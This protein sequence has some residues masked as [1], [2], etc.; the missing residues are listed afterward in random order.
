[1]HS[2]DKNGACS[3]NSKNLKLNFIDF[4]SAYQKYTISTNALSNRTENQMICPNK[5]NFVNL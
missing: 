5:K 4:S 1:M 3:Q 2:G